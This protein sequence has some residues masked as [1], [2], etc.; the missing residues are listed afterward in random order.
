MTQIT[1]VVSQTKIG[2]YCLLE[3]IGESGRGL[4]WT[5]LDSLSGKTVAIKVIP[6]SVVADEVLR[7]RFAQE[8]Q[9]ARKLN[10][11][12]IVRVLDFGLDGS[13]PYLVMEHVAGES[14]GQRL[15]RE[16]R[17]PEAEAVRLIVQIGQALHW[18]HER[19]LVHRDVK[20]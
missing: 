17:V 5:A 6:E 4:V 12:H 16:G 19:R 2:D 8:C 1:S 3:K 7:M 11:P 10:H 20:P 15:E 9:V 18:A 13:K 14:L